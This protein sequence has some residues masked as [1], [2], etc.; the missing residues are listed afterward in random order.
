MIDEQR[1]FLKED[2]ER[3]NEMLESNQQ[4]GWMISRNG[5]EQIDIN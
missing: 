4:D 3:R 1:G 5:R 2:L